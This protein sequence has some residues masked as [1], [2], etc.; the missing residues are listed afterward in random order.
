MLGISPISSQAP[1]FTVQYSTK[2]SVVY[3]N[4]ATLWQEQ[5]N[6]DIGIQSSKAVKSNN[7][8]YGTMA[9]SHKPKEQTQ[10]SPQS[11][12]GVTLQYAQRLWWCRSVLYC[13]VLYRSNRYLI[14]ENHPQLKPLLC[15]S[16][17][18]KLGGKK[19]KKIRFYITL[20]YNTMLIQ[21]INQSPCY[22]YYY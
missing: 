20:Q 1:R 3:R 21:S 16:V 2:W 14:K 17:S 13:T 12:P 4:I 11:W 7:S 18:F 9:T 6:H 10:T 19:S 15:D 22:C 8:W 5:D